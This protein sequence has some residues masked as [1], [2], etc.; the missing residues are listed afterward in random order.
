M[1]EPLLDGCATA[2]LFALVEFFQGLRDLLATAHSDDPLAPPRAAGA[3]ERLLAL[4]G[5]RLSGEQR[6]EQNECYAACGGRG[7]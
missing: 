6:L 1:G 4:S 2:G 5:P 3:H 7:E